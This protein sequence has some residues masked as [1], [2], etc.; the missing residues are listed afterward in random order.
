MRERTDSLDVSRDRLTCLQEARPRR[1]FDTPG[2]G[3]TRRPTLQHVTRKQR[4]ER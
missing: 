1:A 4:D 2:T 3:S